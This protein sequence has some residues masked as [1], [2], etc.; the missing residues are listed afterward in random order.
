MIKFERYPHANDLIVFYMEE[1]KRSDI[2]KIMVYGVGGEADAKVFCQFIWGMFDQIHKDAEQGKSVLGRLDNTDRLPDL[3]YEVTS[4]MRKKGFF[5]V[6]KESV[7]V[8]S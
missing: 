2:A 1:G 3:S 6:W 8:C 7:G 5:S 4:Y